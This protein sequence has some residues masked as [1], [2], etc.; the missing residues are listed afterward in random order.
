MVAS[1]LQVVDVGAFVLL[2]VVVL[3]QCLDGV[4][5]LRGVSADL[6]EDLDRARAGMR[7]GVPLEPLKELVA[8]G[9]H[10]QSSQVD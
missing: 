5:I 1:F 7:F 2:G 9:D 3:E 10:L 4:T 6:R 8:H